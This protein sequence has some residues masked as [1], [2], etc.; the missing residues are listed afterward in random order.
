MT[1][2]KIIHWLADIHTSDQ[3]IRFR[4]SKARPH[5]T[6]SN[7]HRKKEGG[8]GEGGGGEGVGGGGW[9]ELS[10]KKYVASYDKLQISFC[11]PTIFQKKKNAWIKKDL[12][13]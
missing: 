7:I 6:Y 3:I 2:C 5:N 1:H 13:L 8:G 4:P 11:D 12:S 10:G 9:E